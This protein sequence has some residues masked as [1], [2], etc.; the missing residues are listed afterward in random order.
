MPA[1]LVMVST[2]LQNSLHPLSTSSVIARRDR[3]FMVQG[4]IL[5]IDAP[6]ILLDATPSEPHLH[7]PPIFMLSAL[8]ATMHLSCLQCFDAVGWA[9]G[10]ASGL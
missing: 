4:K 7:H 1:V 10:R 5:E 6:T 3:D 2:V 9:A 8:S